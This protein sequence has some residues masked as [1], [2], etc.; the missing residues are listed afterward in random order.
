M[1]RDEYILWSG[2]KAR[3]VMRYEDWRTFVEGMISGD[4]VEIYYVPLTHHIMV[5]G[6]EE[7]GGYFYWKEILNSV[8]KVYRYDIMFPRGFYYSNSAHL[9]VRNSERGYESLAAYR[10]VEIN[11]GVPMG[12]IEPGSED[13]EGPVPGIGE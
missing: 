5:G 9:W 7:A 11:P 8:G 1:K 12:E 10:V 4:Y 13:I 6:G 2:R 3:E